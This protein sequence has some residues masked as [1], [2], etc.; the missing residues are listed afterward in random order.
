MSL[1]RKFV[2]I[3]IISVCSIAIVNIVAFYVFYNSYIR[4]YL[5]EKISARQDITIEY[6]NNII[7][8]Q[9]LDDIDAI[10]SDVELELFEL[11]DLWDGTISLREEK[12]VNIVVDFLRKSGVSPEYIEEV[13]PENNLEKVLELLQN[14][15]SPETLFVKRLSLSLILTNLVMLIVIAIGVLIVTKR[16]ILP[17]KKATNQIRVLEIGSGTKKIEYKKRD[18][19]GLLIDAINGLNIRLWVQEKIR[20]RLLA[21][22]SH[23][24][25][26]PIT[27]IQC[28]LEG[29]IDWVID[30]SEENLSSITWEMSR[31]ITLV[32]QIMKYEKF[33]NKDLSVLKKWTN[34]YSLISKIVETQKP[35]LQDSNQEVSINWSQNIEILLDEN[36]FT[37]VIYNVIWNFQKY[38]G[39]WKNLEITI[40]SSEIVFSDNGAGI[41]KRE[42][43]FLFEKFF[44]GK[45]EKTWNSSVRWI[46]VGLSVV[47]K[48]TEAHWW[49]IEVSSD[50]W[51]WFTLKILFS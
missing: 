21:D 46:W 50:T 36:L 49:K 33:E 44:Q 24:L 6:I 32:N 23:E 13:I 3:L 39:D 34:P 14:P 12:N 45:K 29:I 4:L 10:F 28:Y 19:I 30:L 5:S 1:S 38:A 8:R 20:S 22:I 25:K 41:A 42:V 51:K 47:K 11:L 15:Q 43:P 40:S 31:L 27:S 48:I 9:T 2:I 16:I 7:E 18:E 37:Q 35:Q 17:I 26:T